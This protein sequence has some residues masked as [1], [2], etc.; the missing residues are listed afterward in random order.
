MHIFLVPICIRFS[1]SS[2][3]K[4]RHVAKPRQC[5]RGPRMEEKSVKEYSPFNNVGIPRRWK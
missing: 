2:L 3:A 1:I 5:G 4:A